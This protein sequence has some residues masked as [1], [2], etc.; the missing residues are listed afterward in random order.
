MPLSLVSEGAAVLAS[1]HT[2]VLINYCSADAAPDAH[3][4]DHLSGT[5]GAAKWGGEGWG[6][7]TAD[8]TVGIGTASND[9]RAT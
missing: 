6:L 8:W 3:E 5:G 9:M 7:E 1:S 2:S 4:G